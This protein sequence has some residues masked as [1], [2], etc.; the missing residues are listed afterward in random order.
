MFEIELIKKCG[1]E[2]QIGIGTKIVEK[3]NFIHRY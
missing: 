3:M 1:S 2:E